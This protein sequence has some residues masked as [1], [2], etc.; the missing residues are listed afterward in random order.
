MFCNHC[1]NQMSEG[2]DFCSRC[3]KQVVM[4]TLGSAGVRKRLLRPRDGRKIAGV[5]RGFADYFEVDVAIVRIIW[6]AA[7]FCGLLGLVAYIAAW[8]VMPEE[9][10]ALPAGVASE[11]KRAANL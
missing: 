11:P 10:L 2:S 3:G 7:A 4:G 1:G 8:I 5:C 9:P 6:I